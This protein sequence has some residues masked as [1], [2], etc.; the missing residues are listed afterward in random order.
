LKWYPPF[1]AQWDNLPIAQLYP[2]CMYI[3][4]T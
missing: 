4:N 1:K 3:E 2:K